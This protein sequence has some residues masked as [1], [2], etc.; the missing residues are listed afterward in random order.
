M[1]RYNPG[2]IFDDLTRLEL[3]KIAQALDTEDERI[4]LAVLH[5]APTKFRAGTIVLAD[6]ADWNPGAGAGFYGY[7]SGVWNKLG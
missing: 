4:T 3:H 7:H 5:A 6:G 2:N 1:G